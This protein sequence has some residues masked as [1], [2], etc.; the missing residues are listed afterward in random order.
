MKIISSEEKSECNFLKNKTGVI[1]VD[2]RE[3]IDTDNIRCNNIECTGGF[4]TLFSCVI[5]LF[6]LL[7]FLFSTINTNFVDSH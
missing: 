2:K 1:I 5:C 7:R 6:V 4:E 3:S